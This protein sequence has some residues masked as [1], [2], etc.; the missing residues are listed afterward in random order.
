MG[1]DRI[2][3][4][5]SIF[6][7]RGYMNVIRVFILQIAFQACQKGKKHY[8]SHRNELHAAQNNDMLFSLYRET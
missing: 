3:G 4:R 5:L 7:G 2:R 1:V 6:C 8:R